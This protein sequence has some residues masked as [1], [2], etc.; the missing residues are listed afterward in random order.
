[1]V[2]GG[3]L[4]EVAALL[5]LDLDPDLPVMKAIG[6][7][8]FAAHLRGAT[9]LADAVAQAKAESRRYAKRQTTWFRQQMRD[10]TRIGN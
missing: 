5:R 8:A 10:W 2:D 9:T 6:V 3:A 1:M 7:R 4:D